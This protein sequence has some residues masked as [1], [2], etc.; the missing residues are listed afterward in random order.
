MQREREKK[1]DNKYV[2]TNYI[3]VGFFIDLTISKFDVVFSVS[4]TFFDVFFYISAFD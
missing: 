2:Y 1:K 4:V 3:A